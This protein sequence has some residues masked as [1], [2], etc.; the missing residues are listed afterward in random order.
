[1]LSTDRFGARFFG[2]LSNGTLDPG[3]LRFVALQVDR[4][5][6]AARVIT[7]L[8][9]VTGVYSASMAG[10]QTGIGASGGSV[11]P[12]A[13][14]LRMWQYTGAAAEISA[15]QIKTIGQTLGFTFGW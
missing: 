4:T 5:N 3:G 13:Q 6:S 7:D 2:N 10:I 14:V 11:P 12:A 9:N 15:A 8:E 1:M